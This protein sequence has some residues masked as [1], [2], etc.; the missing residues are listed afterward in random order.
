M[1]LYHPHF[2]PLSC[3]VCVCLVCTE[4][5]HSTWCVVFSPPPRARP[6]QGPTLLTQAFFWCLARLETRCVLCDNT[7]YHPRIISVGYSLVLVKVGENTD[8][9]FY[10]DWICFQYSFWQ[11]SAFY[12]HLAEMCPLPQE[13]MEIDFQIM[14]TNVFVLHQ[15]TFR[16]F[17]PSSS[18]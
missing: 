16:P 11:R 1:T 12:I 17:E 3:V 7:H 2:D 14:W 5:G 18:S 8:N 4:V 9:L 13:E 6:S 10:T 15:M